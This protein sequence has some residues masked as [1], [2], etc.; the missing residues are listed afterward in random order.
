MYYFLTILIDTGAGFL[1]M[2]PFLIL[3][4]ILAR[5]EIPYIPLKHLIGDGVFCFFLSSVLALTGVP[6]FYE[7][8]LPSWSAASFSGILSDPAGALGKVLLFLPLGFLLPLL[9]RKYQKP[10]RCLLYGFLFSLAMQVWQLF[11]FRSMNAG[12][13]LWNMLGMIAGFGL[14]ALW[15]ALWPPTAEAMSL[16]DKA[17][18][19][20][21]ALLE[22]ESGF[23]TAAACAGAF[24]MTSA[25]RGWIWKIFL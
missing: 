8:R 9:F 6:S 7:M 11:S 14:F 4:E 10:S 25:V 15:R 19:S 12:D 20:L 21:P 3:L 18:S 5:R 1:S 24:F 23:L 2:L 16:S 17:L 13:L 22:L